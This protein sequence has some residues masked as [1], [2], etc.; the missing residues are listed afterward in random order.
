MIEGNPDFAVDFQEPESILDPDKIDLT[1]TIVATLY[2]M[3]ITD[4]ILDADVMWTRYSEDA[5]ETRERQ[6]TTFGVCATPIPESL[7]TS[8][9]RTWTLT[10]I[11]LK[12]YALRLPL[13]YVTA[14]ATK[15]QRRQSVTSINLNIAQL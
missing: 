6:A 12:L 1:L 5:E 3:N 10:A 9:P 15:Q 14:W 2:N 4:D 8:Q 11:C 7:Y 13:L